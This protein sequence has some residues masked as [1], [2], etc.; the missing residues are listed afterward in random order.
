MGCGDTVPTFAEVKAF[1]K[2][3]NCHSTQLREAARHGA[4][5][6]VDFDSESAA[7]DK[8]EEAAALV[9]AGAMPPPGSGVALSDSE[10]QDLLR[11]SECL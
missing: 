1:A 8:A 7:V 5:A 10:K 4:P 11:W 9:R 3:S 6:S 2:C